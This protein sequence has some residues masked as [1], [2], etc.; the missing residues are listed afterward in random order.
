MYSGSIDYEYKFH[1]DTLTAEK[2]QWSLTYPD[3][4]SDTWKFYRK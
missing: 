4:H 3:G 2:L 1:L